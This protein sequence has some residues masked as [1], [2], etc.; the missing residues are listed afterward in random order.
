MKVEDPVQCVQPS[1]D[2]LQFPPT[3]G[4]EDT[5]PL[6]FPPSDH[7][8][9]S[10]S[11]AST[12]AVVASFSEATATPTNADDGVGATGVGSENSDE[13]CDP[14]NGSET[15][16][17]PPV[18]GVMPEAEA[19]N[20][21]HSA[22]APIVE[23]PAAEPVDAIPVG[24]PE[25]VEPTPDAVNAVVSEATASVLPAEFGHQSCS[26][27][28][29][30]AETTT[31]PASTLASL[32]TEVLASKAILTRKSVEELT[33]SLKAFGKPYVAP[34]SKAVSDLVAAATAHLRKS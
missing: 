28:E 8:P 12:T 25:A 10:P 4:A 23:F 29:H 17:E 3:I 18:E 31:E 16:S 11:P 33:A 14:S 22:T 20:T 7:T 6:A 21:N 34:K 30:V 13:A 2:L 15:N 27:G 5:A 19:G 9:P 1:L 32:A 26:S 24:C